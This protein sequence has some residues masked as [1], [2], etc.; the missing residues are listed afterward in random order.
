MMQTLGAISS[1]YKNA[2]IPGKGRS[3]GRTNAQVGDGLRDQGRNFFETQETAD[4]AAKAFAKHTE[5]A[6]IK[7]KRSPRVADAVVAQVWI[8]AMKAA[9]NAAVK[10]IEGGNFEGGGSST[11]TPAYAARKQSNVGFTMPIGK[12]T[13]ELLNNLAQHVGNITVHKA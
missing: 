8:A 5:L 7:A 10:N 6:A 9:A 3:D 1:R 11:L 13:G 4:A 2:T 12:A